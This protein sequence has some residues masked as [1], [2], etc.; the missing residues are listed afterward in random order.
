MLGSADL[1][2][3]EQEMSGNI[4]SM[5]IRNLS[6][7]WQCTRTKGKRVQL[8]IAIFCS[9]TKMQIMEFLSPKYSNL[10]WIS[11]VSSPQPSSSFLKTEYLGIPATPFDRNSGSHLTGPPKNAYS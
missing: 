8:D 2:L 9:N 10:G 1:T 5:I 7:A 4:N 3:I 6:R 11:L